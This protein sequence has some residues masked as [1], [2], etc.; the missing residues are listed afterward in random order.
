MITKPRRFV[1]AMTLAA[2]AGIMGVTSAGAASASPAHPALGGLQCSVYTQPSFM[3]RNLATSVYA[4]ANGVLNNTYRATTSAGAMSFCPQGETTN[5]GVDYYY[6]DDGNGFCLTAN[7]NNDETY[8]GKCGQ[9]PGSQEWHYYF[10]GTTKY[11]TL[12]NYYTG[13]CLWFTGQ[14]P[15]ISDGIHIGGCTPNENTEIKEEG[16]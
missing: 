5:G 7:A 6:Y 2:M 9:Y 12:E 8:E 11:G 16:N 15:A 13:E 3:I 14:P 10:N 4:T 1:I